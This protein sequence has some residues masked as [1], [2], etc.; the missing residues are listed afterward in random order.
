MDF[1]DSY[2]QFDIAPISSYKILPNGFLR[3]SAPFF[4]TTN[5]NEKGIR[6]FD[7]EGKPYY[8]KVS[9]ELL[10]RTVGTFAA[11]SITS[12]HPPNKEFI[13]STN[14]AALTKGLTGTSKTSLFVTDKFAWITGTVFDEELILDIKNKVKSEISPG[15]LASLKSTDQADVKDRIDQIGN[16]LA[17]LQSGRM[18][19]TVSLNIDSAEDYESTIDYSQFDSDYVN[20]IQ[21]DLGNLPD[22]FIDFSINQETIKLKKDIVTM[23]TATIVF[24]NQAF[25]IQCD[26]ADQVGNHLAFLQ[27]GRMGS[28]VSLNI[29]SADKYESTIDYLQF[30]SDYVNLIQS[31][32]GNLPDRFLDF[33]INPDKETIKLKKDIVTMGTA[34]LVYN[35]QA[36]TIQCDQADQVATIFNDSQ[37][38]IA[39]LN[40]EKSDL[41]KQNDSLKTDSKTAREKSEA[42]QL[43]LDSKESENQTDAK[44]TVE[45]KAVEIALSMFKVL[46]KLLAVNPG[47]VISQ[48]SLDETVLKRDFLIE[49]LPDQKNTLM[50]MNLDSSTI[51]GSKNIGKIE[52]LFDLKSEEL[53]QKQ[54]DSTQNKPYSSLE[55]L[56]ILLTANSKQQPQKDETPDPMKAYIASIDNNF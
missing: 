14:A 38:E 15:Y 10:D 51:A 12:N 9:R 16:H 22:R 53:D 4:R 11:S 29:D 21:S 50:L 47:Y 26:Q 42:L 46:P 8:Q 41:V 43:T 55:E 40:T 5:A 35:N 24:N 6:Y 20:L 27:S 25:T 7:K 33:S 17:F 19:S 45:N 49:V 52:A 39:T 13:D 36:F 1:M 18:G 32:L 48:D 2:K 54:K 56:K 44:E 28:T 31:D 23:G 37:K 3:F 30:D 34:T